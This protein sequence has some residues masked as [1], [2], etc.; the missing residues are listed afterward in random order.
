MGKN[1]F[2][3]I[4]KDRK[5]WQWIRHHAPKPYQS[6]PDKNKFLAGIYKKIADRTYYPT[7]PQ[8]YITSN[9]GLGVLRVIPALSLEDLCVYYYCARKLE[10]YIAINRVPGTFG[11]F[12][13]SGKLRQIEEEEISDTMNSFDVVGID[14]EYYIFLEM[15]GYLNLSSLNPKAWF[16]EWNDFTSKLYF[17]SSEYGS[18]FVAELDV[19]NFYDSI[20]LDNLEYK[21]RKF[22]PNKCNDIIYLTTHFLRFWNRHINF[23]RQ[24]GAGIPQDSFGEGS[25]I[26]ANFYLQAYD[27]RIHDFCQTKNAIFFRYA[28]DQIFFAKSRKDLEEII[29][30]AS[31]FLM[32]EGL[33]F[34][35]KK[36]KIMSIR[37]FRKYYAFENFLA[38]AY[39]KDEVIPVK[40]V[41]EQITFYMKNKN[42]LKKNGLSLLRRLLSVLNK[43][44]TKPNNFLRLKKYL[45][46]DFL[47]NNYSV[48]VSDMD[49]IYS[50]LN[51]KEKAKML[52]IL[53]KNTE[54][55]LYTGYL[56]ELKR[57]YKIYRIP[58]RKIG[59]RITFLNRFYNF[60]RMH[61]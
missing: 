12:G 50:I 58:I 39:K 30:K 29:T 22:V 2:I 31:S 19:S 26:L 49:R 4:C 15:N 27:Q 6:V 16:A 14:D 1:E 41:K 52:N 46:S 51:K 7:P 37:S 13:L 9:K 17:N 57:F 5:F 3:N 8:E 55:S 48:S 43:M 53:N 47:P 54:N 33:N 60:Q 34:N 23:Y 10:K 42:D 36:V 11:G 40:S 35:Q 21:L 45:L 38:L 32:R 25:R 56:Y 24:Q 20:Q 28:D 61:S 44:K 18:G 59:L